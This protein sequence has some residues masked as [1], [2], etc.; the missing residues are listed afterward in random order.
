M[1]RPRSRYYAGHQ[2]VP[3]LHRTVTA[4]EPRLCRTV[5]VPIS[6]WATCPPV[7]ST[8]TCRE[9][10]SAR[11]LPPIPWKG[12]SCPQTEARCPAP[13]PTSRCSSRQRR[14]QS[15]C[16][17]GSKPRLERPVRVDEIPASIREVH[18]G[19]PT[20]P[21]P[22]RPSPL[23]PCQRPAGSS[24]R[25]FVRR[26]LHLL[27]DSIHRLRYAIRRMARQVFA[28]RA[29][30]HFAPRPLRP[31]REG[32]SPLKDLIW[33][34]NRCL[35]TLSITRYNFRSTFTLVTCAERLGVHLRA[36]VCGRPSVSAAPA[37]WTAAPRSRPQP[38]R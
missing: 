6:P 30:I 31:V 18:Q 10:Q 33:D 1:Q 5:Q 16:D 19:P 8:W 7:Q 15:T 17:C 38:P 37:G 12:R 25:K 28:E 24:R 9:S 36:A 32:L 35:H 14:P 27:K 4:Q 23:A 22:G 26:L 29:C 11:R 2:A 34:G 13:M 3:P 21:R 20:T